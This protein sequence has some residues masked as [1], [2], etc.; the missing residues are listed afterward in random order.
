MLATGTLADAIGVGLPALVSDWP[1]LT[2]MLGDAGIRV[3]HTAAEIAAALDGAHA[4][5]TRRGPRRDGRAAPCAS[6]GAPIAARTA[7][8]FERVVLDEP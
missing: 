7:D 1:F 5:A 8:L 4:R 2:E 3:G 6:T